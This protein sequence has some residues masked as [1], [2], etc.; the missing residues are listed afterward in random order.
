MKFGKINF[1]HYQEEVEELIEMYGEDADLCGLPIL[2][3][4]AD[5]HPSYKGKLDYAFKMWE[6]SVDPGVFGSL[7]DETCAVLQ[8]YARDYKSGS[9]VFAEYERENIKTSIPLIQQH[10]SSAVF[11]SDLQYFLDRTTYSH[12][13]ERV[14][15]HLSGVFGFELQTVSIPIIPH[16]ISEEIK[17][18]IKNRKEKTKNSTLTYVVHNPVT[19]LYKIGKTRNLKNRLN[20]LSSMSGVSLKL[21][22]VFHSDME[23]VLHRTFARYRVLGEWFNDVDGLIKKYILQHKEAA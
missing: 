1:V 20:C 5:L 3:E 9:D 16:T 6:Q 13:G 7:S 2:E 23:H 12:L 14:A 18:D 15:S 19:G 4:I 21:M 11:L 10:I 17:Q 8:L 22:H